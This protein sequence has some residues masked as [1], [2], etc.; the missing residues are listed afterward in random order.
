MVGHAFENHLGFTFNEH[1]L[2]YEKG[3]GAK[4][5]ENKAKP[6]FLFPSFQAYHE[7][8]YDVSR[9]FLL[10]AKTTCKGK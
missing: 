8:G 7:L 9:I 4:V 10:G 1:C 2:Q 6:D 3:G 5:T